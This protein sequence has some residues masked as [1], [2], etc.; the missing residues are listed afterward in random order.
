MSLLAVGG[1][2]G[3][4]LLSF[5]M[6]SLIVL[7]RSFKVM[8]LSGSVMRRC[9]EMRFGGWMRRQCGSCHC[10]SFLPVINDFTLRMARS[11]RKY[12]NL[13]R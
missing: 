1:R 11:A 4:M 3:Y 10:L 6:F 7:M 12:R 13:L 8:V 5:V 9:S 2:R